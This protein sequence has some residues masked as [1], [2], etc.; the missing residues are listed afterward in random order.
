M[1]NKLYNFLKQI[2]RALQKTKHLLKLLASL[3]V[4]YFTLLH[5]VLLLKYRLDFFH[6]FC[7]KVYSSFEVLFGTI[8]TLKVSKQSPLI[9][10]TIFLSPFSL[11][12]I[13][14]ELKVI[15]LCHQL[16]LSQAC[17]FSF[18]CYSFE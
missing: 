12:L 18:L 7:Q 14:L 11:T 4:C 16:V 13:L 17:Q 10:I 1:E 3:C 15:S 2:Q 9:T 5:L 8:H 6:L